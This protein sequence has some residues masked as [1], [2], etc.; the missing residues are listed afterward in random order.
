VG[1]CVRARSYFGDTMN[2]DVGI[3]RLSDWLD[4]PQLEAE[5]KEL[6]EIEQWMKSQ[7]K[8]TWER[9]VDLE[10]RLALLLKEVE[11]ITDDGGPC[12]C[13]NQH[14]Y[15]GRPL[16]LKQK[17]MALIGHERLGDDCDPILKTSTAYDV[18]YEE[19]YAALP[20]CRG[21]CG[22]VGW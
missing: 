14:F 6:H 9:L 8:P 22:C 15:G 3:V 7:P 11:A 16:S 12:F 5:M 17:M 1:K 18:A 20:D 19:L 4:D 13:A 10:P 21:N 2:E